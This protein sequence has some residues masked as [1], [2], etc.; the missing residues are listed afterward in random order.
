MGREGAARL[1]G[2]RERG[3]PRSERHRAWPASAPRSR[4]VDVAQSGGGAAP[5]EALCRGAHCAVACGRPGGRTSA[6]RVHPQA[7][8]REGA[9]PSVAVWRA[10]ALGGGTRGVCRGGRV[11]ASLAAAATARPHDA[12]TSGGLSFRAPSRPAGSALHA[13]HPATYA[14]PR[15][16]AV[17]AYVHPSGIYLVAATATPPAT[18]VVCDARGHLGPSTDAAVRWRDDAALFTNVLAMRA[19]V[20]R[21]RR[22]C[23]ST[24]AADRHRA[25]RR[26]Q[27]ARRTLQRRGRR[28]G[29]APR[30]PSVQSAV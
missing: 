25:R 18:T 4:P 21:R 29:G 14:M 7:P 17:F 19:A 24:A 27:Q 30:H 1:G 28:G 22:D 23:W 11:R 10:R 5:L 12:R 16:A 13:G 9:A 6:S 26:R 2:G 20:V 8:R 15:A 3:G